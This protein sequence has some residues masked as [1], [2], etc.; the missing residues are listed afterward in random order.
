[1]T[2]HESE[3]CMPKHMLLVGVIIIIVGAML[4]AMMMIE[5]SQIS[6]LNAL[7]LNGRTERL[8][9]TKRLDEQNRLEDIRIASLEVLVN[10]ELSSIK[11]SLKNLENMHSEQR[12]ITNGH[13]EKP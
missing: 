5:N 7:L 9:D 2:I 11:Q 13:V 4:S 6:T 10:S 8:N 3:A 1:M 12:G